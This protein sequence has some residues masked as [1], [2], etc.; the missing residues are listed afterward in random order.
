MFFHIFFPFLVAEPTKIENKNTWIKCTETE[1]NYNKWHRPRQAR[2]KLEKY[3][4]EGNKYV[5]L[6]QAKPIS[7]RRGRNS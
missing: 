2:G 3:F 1:S 4:P 5:N 7:Y 6:R